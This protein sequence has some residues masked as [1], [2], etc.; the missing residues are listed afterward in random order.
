MCCW[1]G[2]TKPAEGVMQGR[3]H[4]SEQMQEGLAL[5]SSLKLR[6]RMNL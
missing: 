3:R 4:S 2:L 5:F 1:S 6:V